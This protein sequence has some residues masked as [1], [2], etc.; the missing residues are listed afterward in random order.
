MEYIGCVSVYKV[1]D[2][3][4]KKVLKLDSSYY[5]KAILSSVNICIDDNDMV[6][7]GGAYGTV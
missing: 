3:Q 5:Y 4:E 1:F 7:Y 6:L 2:F